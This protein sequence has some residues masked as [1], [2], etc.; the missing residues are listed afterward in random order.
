MKIEMTNKKISPRN[1]P[2]WNKE[3][4]RHSWKQLLI[5]KEDLA[6]L[7]IEKEKKT[8]SLKQ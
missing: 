3:Y 4:N 1:N 6:T 2:L 8:K 5:Y 7:N